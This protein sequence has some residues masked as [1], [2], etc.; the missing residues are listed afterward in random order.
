M[1]EHIAIQRVD[2]WVVDVGLDHALLEVVRHD[3][4]RGTT[5]LKSLLDDYAVL[6][7]ELQQLGERSAGLGAV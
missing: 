3:D 2:R 4:A 5:V 1:R 6:A 7:G